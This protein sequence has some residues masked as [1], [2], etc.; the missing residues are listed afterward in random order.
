MT[1]AAVR[2]LIKARL[3]NRGDDD[4]LD[5]LIL[6]EL[7]AQM[8]QLEDGPF[9]P[10][11]MIQDSAEGVI[12]PSTSANFPSGFLCLVDDDLD[13]VR[14]VSDIG[15]TR[16]LRY[17][18]RREL[19]QYAVAANQ[20]PKWFSIVK[21]TLYWYPAGDGTGTITY[22]Y[23]GRST[24]LT[25]IADVEYPAWYDEAPMVLVNR[26]AMQIAATYLKDGEL[27]QVFANAFQ[28]AYKQLEMRDTMRRE[29][30][31]DPHD[32][33]LGPH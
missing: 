21:D 33:E 9:W 19:E 10:W 20:T 16:I 13:V 5:A 23:Y 26:V 27:A 8:V 32:H 14:F 28:E 25:T 3:A 22:R 29:Q 12:G 11:F 31:R 7:N 15:D 1:P 2:D 17:K 6:V 30:G 4:T 18:P 24:P